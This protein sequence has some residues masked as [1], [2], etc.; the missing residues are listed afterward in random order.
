[1]QKVVNENVTL[2]L[3]FHCVDVT[4]NNQAHLKEAVAK[5]PVSCN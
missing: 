3:K 1:M 4:P 2:L 5:G